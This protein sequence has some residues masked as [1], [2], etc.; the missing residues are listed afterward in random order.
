MTQVREALL[1]DASGIS[2]LFQNKISVWQRINERGY[3]D[4][5]H[6]EDLTVYERWTHGGV[7]MSIETASIH[8]SRMR[9][10][11]G[12]ALVAVDEGEIVGFAEIYP[13]DE[14]EPFGQ[15]LYISRL[16]TSPDFLT[17]ADALMRYVFDF[18]EAHNIQRVAVSLSG[19]NDEM[20]NFYVSYGLTP[21]ETVS[22]Y[23]LKA[24]S[25]QVFYKI[26]EHYNSN[27]TQIEGWQMPVGRITSARE[28]W[29]TLF[30]RHWDV[31]PEIAKQ[32]THRLLMSC[33]GQDVFVHCQADAY[34]PRRATVSCW[35][36]K[37]L[38]TQILTAIRDW[39]HRENYRNLLWVVNDETARLFKGEGENDPYART[40]FSI[41]VQ[42]E[43]EED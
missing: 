18:S 15:H 14:P 40:I 7:W 25:G 17:A 43:D 42:P 6:Y 28:R 41:D 2:Q 38:S 3:V 37:K 30:T 9:R 19:E 8:L 23:T 39:A 33:S 22:R 35:S 11:A 13:G 21:I 29:E 20:Y 10:G 32:R 36:Q 34:D 26:S 16:I 24:R 31:I 12:F 4:T 5:V 1:D 27:A